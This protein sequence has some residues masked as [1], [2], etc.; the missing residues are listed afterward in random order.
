MAGTY[1]VLTACHA[2]FIGLSQKR[3][4]IDRPDQH[5]YRGAA[6][7]LPMVPEARHGG[8]SRSAM[9]SVRPVLSTTIMVWSILDV[10]A[11]QGRV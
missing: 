7:E 3:R 10:G 1:Q 8:H 9:V 11:L 6:S 2:V 4:Q 5:A